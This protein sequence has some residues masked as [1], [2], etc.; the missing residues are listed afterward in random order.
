VLDAR[1]HG[2]TKAYTMVN[3]SVGKRFDE[4]HYTVTFKT[5]NLFNQE[6]MQHIFGDVLKRQVM[7]ELHVNWLK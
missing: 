4:G 5:V 6:V 1:Y 2:T 3:A 7:I